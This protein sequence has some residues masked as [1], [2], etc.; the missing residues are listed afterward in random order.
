MKVSLV[1]LTLMLQQQVPH[2]NTLINAGNIR[3]MVH[4]ADSDTLAVH[5]LAML[6]EEPSG[7]LDQH[8]STMLRIVMNVRSCFSRNI[9]ISTRG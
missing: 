6:R 1:I 5:L 3:R 8:N 4:S 9:T 2:A 7:A